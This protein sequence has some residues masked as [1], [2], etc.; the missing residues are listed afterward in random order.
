MAPFARALVDADGVW[1]TRNPDDC[2]PLQPYGEET[3]SPPPTV[4]HDFFTEWGRMLD[5]SDK[6]MLNQ[7]TTTGVEG[8]SKCSQARRRR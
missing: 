3:E 7:V 1:D 6:D 8:R 5:W 4:N 2:V